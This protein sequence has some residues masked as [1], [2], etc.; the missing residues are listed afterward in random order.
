MPAHQ[1]AVPVARARHSY[2]FKKTE[3]QNP[4]TGR[5]ETMRPQIRFSSS[6]VLAA[7]CA[8]S[9]VAGEYREAGR[10]LALGDSVVFGYI[11]QAGHAY[12]SADNFIGSP[13]YLRE[14]LHMDTVNAG[15]P[16]ETTASFLSSSGADN[17]C[18]SFR[19]AFPLHVA[20]SSTQL[21]FATDFLRQHPGTNLVTIGV[22]AN[23]V[24][25]LQKACAGD[26]NP[27]QC[28]QA[29]L[30]AVLGA[31]GTNMAVTLAQL[32]ATGFGGVIVVVNYYS[33][34]YSDP[35]QT[36][37]TALLN[38]AIAAPAMAYGA[39]VA[40]V[41]SA[42]QSAVSSPTVGGKTCNAGLLNVDP[43][44]PTLC[45]VHPSQSG[46]RLIAKTIARVYD[47]ATR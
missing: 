19:A 4:I 46:Q 20:Y 41:F 27:A 12:V 45:D 21:A 17:G 43:Q 14:L 11:T 29:G 31:A 33:P 47:H 32:R 13:E 35:T 8:G 1:T 40:D 15:C 7:L 22:G 10:A 5:E 23:D 2:S 9:A 36:A 38:Q 16:G 39:V 42:F 24:F 28:I 44:D 18:R 34:D 6:L 3:H 30:P 26:P 37:I 25:L